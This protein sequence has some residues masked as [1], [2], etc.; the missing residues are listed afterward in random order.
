MMKKRKGNPFSENFNQY[1]DMKQESYLQTNSFTFGYNVANDNP[2]EN[3]SFEQEENFSNENENLKGNG[4]IFGINS[5]STGNFRT[6]KP[7][8]ENSGYKK[9][10]NL[11]F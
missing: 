11:A 4:K 7:K 8:Y 3:V 2:R 10:R 1:S 9:K 5:V 6:P